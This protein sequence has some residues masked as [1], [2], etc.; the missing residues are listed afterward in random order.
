MLESPYRLSASWEGRSIDRVLS[1]GPVTIG[2]ESGDIVIPAGVVS[3]P[4]LRLDVSHS[5]VTVTDLGST[6]GTFLNRER[7][8]ASVPVAL[9]PGSTLMLGSV[10]Q[11]RLDGVSTGPAPAAQRKG[12]TVID[13]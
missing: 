8:H 7:L 6:N 11:L 5:G 12:A 1:F 4:H 10:V 2:R 13:R 9:R 3:N